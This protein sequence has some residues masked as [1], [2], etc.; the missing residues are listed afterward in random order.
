M[1]A[2][3]EGCGKPQPP[4]WKAGDLCT[5]C[6][7]SVRHDVR[8][9]WCAKWVPAAKFCRS[10][11]AVVVEERLYGA[12]RMLKDAGTDR[13]TIPRQLKEFDPDQID[14]FSRIYQRHAVAIARHVDELRFLERFLFGKSF[15][16]ALEDV[17]VPQL[18]WTE[19]TLARMS[20]PVLPPG[21][22]VATARAIFKT[23]PFAETRSL[24]ALV[25][26]QLRDA[27]SFNDACSA[28][29][30]NDAAI[31]A[32][33]AL[34]LTGWRIVYSWGRPRNL[35]REL[36]EE[37]QRSPHRLEAAVRLGLMNRGDRDLLKEAGASS[38]PETAFAA[39]L[40]LGDVERLQA[41]MKGDDQQKAA[42]GSK[43]ISLGII[44]PVVEPI[45]KSAKEVQWELVDSLA[46]RKEAAPEASETLLEIVETS[47]DR[48]LRERA[49][50]IL[51]RDLKPGWVLRIA[52]KAGKERSIYQNLLQAP[53]LESQ[54]AQELCDFLIAENQFSMNQYGLSDVAEKGI[55]PGTYVPS[56]FPAA[57]EATQ[58]EL[59]RFAEAQIRKEIDEG[60]HR[61]LMN[62]VFGPHSHEIRA[63]AWWS[64]QR[65]YR[66]GGEYRG[67]GPFTLTK[68]QL[69]R[70]FGS[71]KAFLPKLA[72]VLRSQ[73]TM[74]EVGFYDMMA[75]VLRTADGPA[76]A[77][78]HAETK[79]AGDLI[80]ALI[81]AAGGDYWPYTLE[82][83]YTLLSQLGSHPRW[84]ER[85]LS[86]LRAFEKKGNYA[87]DKAVRKLE[88]STYGIP[89]V[90][91]W[92]QLP[93]DFVPLRFPAA[94]RAGRRELLKVAEY[95]M[96][97]RDR[98]TGTP[99]LSRFLLKAAVAA[100]EADLAEELLELLRERASSAYQRVL[101]KPD[102]VAAVYG[103]FSEFVAD[104]PKSLRTA[105][106]SK[107][108]R[109]L[110][111]HTQLLS[112]PEPADGGLL[113]AE[114][115]AG[116]TLVRAL[117]DV[118]AAPANGESAQM[119][120]RRDAVRFLRDGAGAHPAWRVEVVDVLAR[121][122]DTPG[123]D[124]KVECEM[125]LRKIQPPEPPR[126]RRPIVDPRE[127]DHPLPEP[128]PSARPD[129]VDYAALH[130]TAEK[131][132]A[133]LQQKM[134][135]LMAGPGTPEEKMREGTRLSED[136]QAA[137]KKLYGQ[138]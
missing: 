116:T 52:R 131:M 15:S 123:T 101:L 66:S 22:D 69:V 100:D 137:I 111:F 81:E 91:E 87:Y 21:D 138:A 113:E 105:V 53:G 68:D 122:R 24:A 35:E 1:R 132:G 82:S 120:L 71:V 25:R 49:S 59:L 11:G 57:D 85:V 41:A 98:Q 42:A 58:K 77:E 46:R 84:R 50:R 126:I 61:F 36:A 110:E 10:C 16:A 99:V 56:R 51:C 93:E 26:L 73:D 88:L 34:Q 60:L 29:S 30:T 96:I 108:R 43:L 112:R 40:V 20:A 106:Q 18:P 80:E 47:D 90:D 13:F 32:E 67:E 48:T 74:K 76:I 27:D 2:L 23:T 103:S 127:A 31:R 95:Q 6:G 33:A 63:A 39:A 64:L 125:A 115:K 17:L 7:K 79:D 12:A 4:D 14:N 70:F 117:L 55:L 8:C 38:D 133:D 45:A 119:I 124:Q 92:D 3:C 94:D 44:T 121:L 102:A 72:A 89:E 135:L 118:A 75:T 97:H 104:L 107:T 130:R 129:G 134:F 109:V 114:G 9:Y 83:M 86:G 5:T 54:S 128:E 28:F 37:L 65:S 62:V 136:F 19:E 78:M